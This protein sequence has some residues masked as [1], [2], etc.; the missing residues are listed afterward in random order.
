MRHVDAG[1]GRAIKIATERGVTIPMEPT[2][3]D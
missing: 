3:R 1:Y 2:R